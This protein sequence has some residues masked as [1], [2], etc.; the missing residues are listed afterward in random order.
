MAVKAHMK[1]WLQR[2]V[3]VYPLLGA[4]HDSAEAT[5]TEVS[6]DLNQVDTDTVMATA[7]TSGLARWG[8]DLSEVRVPGQ[9]DTQFASMLQAIKQGRA[10][11]FDGVK[12]AVDLWGLPYR[13][14][15][16]G[17]VGNYGDWAFGDTL[18]YEALVSGPC[19]IVLDFS[20]PWG[21]V[22]PTAAQLSTAQQSLVNALKYANRVKAR[23]VQIVALI[24]TVLRY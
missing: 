4:L 22:T 8:V 5:F 9:T 7:S 15:D 20:D 1:R 19:Q 16:A 12:Y 13:M 6:T 21:G 18:A 17:D 24:P 10:V 11:N 14:Y 23:G 3:N 2:L